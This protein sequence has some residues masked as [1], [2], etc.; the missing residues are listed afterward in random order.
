MSFFQIGYLITQ[1]FFVAFF[2]N[3]ENVVKLKESLLCSECSLKRSIHSKRSILM[4]L[5]NLQ[6][7]LHKGYAFITFEGQS[8]EELEKIGSKH[9]IDDQEVIC[10]FNRE[11]QVLPYIEVDSAGKRTG[12]SGPTATSQEGKKFAK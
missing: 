3:L 5:Q 1:S 7:G 12:K 4:H 2:K 8:Q 11:S 6:T 9:I 10:S